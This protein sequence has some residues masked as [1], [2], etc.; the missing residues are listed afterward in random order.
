ML[1]SLTP[2]GWSHLTA[3]PIPGTTWMVNPFKGF[4]KG[5]NT[6]LAYFLVCFFYQYTDELPL[7]FINNL[8][9]VKQ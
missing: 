9:L 6:I 5:K 3:A 7:S 2:T 8:A 1:L 4:Y